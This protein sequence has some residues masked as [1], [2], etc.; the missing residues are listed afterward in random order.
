MAD[1]ASNKNG[2]ARLADLKAKAGYVP[3]IRRNGF[4]Y[5]FLSLLVLYAIF[6]LPAK[7]SPETLDLG[8]IILFCLLL[9][10]WAILI[11]TDELKPEKMKTVIVFTI[12]IIAA[13]LYY[14]Y[15]TARWG[16]MGFLFFNLEMIQKAWP[17]LVE[18][19]WTTLLLAVCAAIMS[20]I[21]GLLLAIFRS[22]ENRVL[23]FFIIA[24]V[25]FFRAMPIIVLMMLIYYA[26]PFMGIRLSAIVSGILAL[27][28][29]SSAYVSEIFRAGFLSVKKGQIEAA[30]ALGL[31][32]IQ[33]MRYV[34]L[35]QAFRV[36]IP[37]LVGNYV[38]S[39]KDTALA[40]S[41]S[42]IELLKAGLSQKSLLA[43]PSP[44][45][46]VTAL[47]LIMFV[48]LTRFSGY[49][50]KRMKASQRQVRL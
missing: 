39:A 13:W 40:S 28:L 16:E 37:P 1:P 33:T 19:F 18:G 6:L 31:N 29:N 42:I 23:N 46:F 2:T 17:T 22:F 36:V 5:A 44:L 25:D 20:T 47:Y 10:V 7:G 21:I 3:V 26:L 27:G 45:I 11:F 32:P 30:N 48:P 43:N 41:I 15:S 4:V 12:F 14:R 9:L 8:R 38:A 24:Y 34:I 49:L 50:E 35:P